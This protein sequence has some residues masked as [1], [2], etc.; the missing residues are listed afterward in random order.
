MSA[1][2]P[3]LP[4]YAVILAVLCVSLGFGCGYLAGRM[5]PRRRKPATAWK[6]PKEPVTY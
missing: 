1:T 2:D 5:S 6:R 4:I 3:M